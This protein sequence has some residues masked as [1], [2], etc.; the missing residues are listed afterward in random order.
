MIVYDLSCDSGHRFEGWF[1][2]G[3]EFERQRDTGLL[4]CPTCGS[5]VVAKAPMAPAVP[6]KR[7]RD[8]APVKPAMPPELHAKL[9]EAV[10]AIAAAQVKALKTSTWVGT[11]LTSETRAMHYGE[12]DEAPIHGRASPEEAKALAEEGIGVMPLLV[13]FTPPEELN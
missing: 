2:S 13:P 10:T 1:G 9:K 4:F 7:A 6:S 5:D 12:K 11:A 8:V 3:T